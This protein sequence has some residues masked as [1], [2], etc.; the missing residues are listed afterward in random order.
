LL[1]AHEHVRSTGSKRASRILFWLG[2][3]AAYRGDFTEA[4]MF[5][6]EAIASVPH[7][8][9]FF[10]AL[11][12]VANAW[13][14]A[15]IGDFSR[16]CEEARQANALYRELG[17]PQWIASTDWRIGESCLELGDADG[18]RQALEEAA[19]LF[20]RLKSAGQIPEV[21]A[22]LARSLVLLGDLTRARERAEIAR[23]VSL[24]TDLESRYIAAVALGEVCEAEG[25][26]DAAEALFRE[27]IAIV[28]PSGLGNVLAA[29][30]VC[31]AR[32]LLRQGRGADARAQ[33]DRARA[34]YRDPLAV[35]HRERI[36]SLLRQAAAPT[37]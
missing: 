24:P 15:D 11:T 36:D 18:A 26:V 35:H 32:F 9:K 27:A 29:A 6:A 14:A 17:V 23:E 22:R 20:E 7:Q 2:R 5:S 37:A 1:D 30:R 31:Y 19:D 21:N 4:G 3:S 10:R 13:F 8:S 12:D 25:D 28:E 33:L 16:S 34:F